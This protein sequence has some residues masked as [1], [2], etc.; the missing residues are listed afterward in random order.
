MYSFKAYIYDRFS[1]CCSLKIAEGIDADNV[2]SHKGT[3]DIDIPMANL[4][5]IAS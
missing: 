4:V 5:V 1:E 3:A 2:T